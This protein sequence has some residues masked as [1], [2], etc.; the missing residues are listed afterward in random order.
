[1]AE[2][3]GLSLVES[4][5]F[6][7]ALLPGY[8]V[9]RH[10]NDRSFESRIGRSVNYRLALS[11]S[12]AAQSTSS[13]NIFVLLLRSYEDKTEGMPTQPVVK[14]N[15]NKRP[16]QT[17]VSSAT[18]GMY[19]KISLKPNDN[20][21]GIPFLFECGVCLKRLNSEQG[22]RTHVYTEHVLKKAKEEAS[23]APQICLTCCKIFR[24]REAL[25]N[26]IA[27]VHAF[28]IPKGTGSSRESS[29]EKEAVQLEIRD[30]YHECVVCALRFPSLEQLQNH[31][32][33]GVPPVDVRLET[34]CSSCGR[35]FKDDRAL[36][37]HRALVHSLSAVDDVDVSHV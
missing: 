22:V 6:S 3:N 15:P 37:Q 36:G 5:P 19:K 21:A 10:H 25:N 7:S 9:K 24:N 29:Y 14:V 26:H 8:E 13:L 35:A 20:D 28:E 12:A 30:K 16:R 33:A 31:L 4:T 2:R 1:M 23:T 17:K 18:E 34:M 32:T 11:T 27:F